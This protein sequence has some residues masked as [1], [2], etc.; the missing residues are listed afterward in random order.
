MLAAHSAST[1]PLFRLRCSQFRGPSL[2]EF[3]L[4]H[5]LPLSQSL[6]GASQSLVPHTACHSLSRFHACGSQRFHASAF[7]ASSQS[8]PWTKPLRVQSLTLPATLSVASM[9]AA[10]SASTLPLFGLYYFIFTS[11]ISCELLSG[12][13]SLEENFR[14]R[15]CRT[16]IIICY[17][18][19]WLLLCKYSQRSNFSV[20]FEAHPPPLAP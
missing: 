10:H 6:D 13:F 4:S 15:Y 8:V 17:Y 20:A 19:Y 12:F 14:K 16:F 7:Q 3:S 11:F 1:L 2:S 18:Y 9:L 5:C